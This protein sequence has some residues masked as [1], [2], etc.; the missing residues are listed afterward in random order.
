M[1][2]PDK[3]LTRVYAA[4]HLAALTLLLATLF[5][6]LR[7]WF[8]TEQAL[9][10]ALIVGSTIRIVLRPGEYWDLSSIPESS[11]FAPASL[12]EPAMIAL[13]LLLIRADRRWLLA[14]LVA[15]AAANS[16][17][18]ALLPVLFVVTR[19]LTR[20]RITA[21]LGY[22]AIWVAREPRGA[23]GRR[24]HRVAARDRPGADRESA[25]PAVVGDQPRVVPR[26]GL[27]AHPDRV[28]ADTRVRAAGDDR[29]PDLP[30]GDRRVGIL[31]GRAEPGAA[32]SDPA[33]AGTRRLVPATRGR[34]TS[35]PRYTL[36]RRPHK[37]DGDDR[38]RV[39]IVSGLLVLFAAIVRTAWIGDDA[40]ITFRT[41]DNIVHGYGP[42][43][44]VAE[45]VQGFTHPLWLA[46]F[47]A[48]YAVTGEPYYTS[49]ALSLALSIV[50]VTLLIRSVARHA[51]GRPDLRGGTRLIQGVRRLLDIGTRECAEPRADRA[52]RVA[53]VGRAP[54]VKRECSAC[55]RWPRSACSTGST[56]R[57]WSARP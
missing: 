43:W 45:R 54:P 56:S 16:E 22:L 7:V 46:V 15:I 5:F 41:A 18:A 8:S 48:F 51:V 35:V 40:Y 32:L 47:T 31:V 20:D 4:Y 24:R 39:F 38:V 9:A 13:G 6:Y 14:A 21:A 29:D 55:R 17:A 30:A 27:A 23:S 19:P 44:N 42:V 28:A 3:A 50:T 53:V 36:P 57:C 1:M 10:G 37:R 12:L 2:P 26:A 25:A 33:A 11:V 49:I 52:V 34:G